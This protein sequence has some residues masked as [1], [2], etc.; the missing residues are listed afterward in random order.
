MKVLVKDIPGWKEKEKQRAEKDIL[1]CGAAEDIHYFHWVG[2]SY[3]AVEDTLYYSAEVD[4]QHFVVMHTQNFVGLGKEYF[5]LVD[6]HLSVEED[7]EYFEHLGD[8]L[9]LAE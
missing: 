3:F 8:I 1:N 9:Q 7:K 4:I 2:M 6:I 5:E